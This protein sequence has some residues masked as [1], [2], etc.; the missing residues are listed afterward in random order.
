M[1]IKSYLSKHGYVIKKEFYEK[2]VLDELKTELTAKPLTNFDN[3]RLNYPV[4]IET[5]SKMYI[6]KMYALKKFGKP[7]GYLKPYLGTIWE[8]E[9][10]FNGTLLPTQEE[11]CD[12]L[13]NSCINEG[14]GILSLMTGGGKC[15]A[16][17]TKI[18]MFDGTLKNVQDVV[19]GDFLMGDDSKHRLVMSLAR[20]T[21]KMF[22][23][24]SS[25]GSVY[26]VNQA[27]I[28]VLNDPVTNHKIHISV[29][30]YLTQ[31][32]SF[33]KQY[34][35]YR[36]S[37][38]F[39]EKITMENPYSYGL[40]CKTQIDST[41]LINS[42][43]NRLLLLAGIIDSNQSIT[44]SVSIVSKTNKF[45]S[46]LQFLC[47]SLGF[48]CKI[49]EKILYINGKIKEIPCNFKQYT[50]ET[51]VSNTRIK[52]EYKG[53][54]KYYGFTINHNRRFLLGDCTV[55]HNT[56]SCL[57][58]LSKLKGKTI[59]VVNKISLL[60]QWES[61]IKQFL[62]K[63]RIGKIQGQKNIDIND[64]DIVLAMLQSLSRIDYPDNFF[65]NINITVFD[66]CHNI[67]SETFSK[68]FFKLTSQYTIGLTAT[69][70]RS[71][72]CENVFKWHI[73]KIVYKSVESTR[74]GLPPIIKLLKIKS[75]EYTEIVTTSKL[76]GKPQVQ[77]TSMLS[78]LVVM[79]KRN[80]LVIE[81]IKDLIKND[82]KQILVMSDR[83]SHLVSLRLL[84]DNDPEATFT[85]GLFLGGMKV[86]DLDHA[87]NCRVIMA[88]CQ[89]FQEGV[90][91]ASLDTLILI[92][93]KKYI[94]HLEHKTVKNEGGK[95]EQLVGR[96]FRRN[97]TERNPII[98]DFQDDFS[99]YKSQANSR[100]VFYK[101][102][103]KNGIYINQS[104]NLDLHED[105]KME[106]IKTNKTTKPIEKNEQCLIE[107]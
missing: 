7:D 21:D 37:V 32:E 98:V 103:F 35:G 4:Y 64:K 82:S 45:I 39:E 33:K 10:K 67:S 85:Y 63:A 94:G 70:V 28:L 60:N 61:E 101:S 73:G 47:Y 25:N 58:V 26:T 53:M 91:V 88:S 5:K 106:Y 90:S 23:I 3:N 12:L 55:T 75:D 93:P 31:S 34:Y 59:I 48:D 20:G 14:G 52:V 100:T 81:I 30:N 92:S 66:E 19:I 11:P 15:L 80:K 86:K 105:V 56:V 87:K 77:F 6:P 8:N 41:Y 84:L 46:D 49:Y 1:S 13:Y 71:D 76:T 78:E 51:N 104:V 107:D 17:N 102:K 44:T 40:T 89:A 50:K 97:H 43:S 95:L 16:K 69:P 22:D 68:V 24:I 74:A 9:I 29:E 38:E 96:I 27:H 62:P 99:I 2:N 42:R 54:G 72:G 18:L 36:V 83:R 79:P 57:N 65:D